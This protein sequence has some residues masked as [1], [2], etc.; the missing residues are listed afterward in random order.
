MERLLTKQLGTRVIRAG[1]TYCVAYTPQRSPT[2]VS[3]LQTLQNGSGTVTSVFEGLLDTPTCDSG[4]E[5]VNSIITNGGT[6]ILSCPDADPVEFPAIIEILFDMNEDERGPMNRTGSMRVK[7]RGADGNESASD[8]F[9]VQERYWD[10]VGGH[11][12]WSL[13]ATVD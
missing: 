9:K 5:P 11:Y 12:V 13:A 10:T 3:N 7:Q 1:S 6:V 8:W 2:L 4:S